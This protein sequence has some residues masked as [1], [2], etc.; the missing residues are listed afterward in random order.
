MVIAGLC[1]LINS[2]AVFLAPAFSRL[3]FPWILLP[4][5]PAELGLALWLLL[6]GVNVGQWKEQPA[7]ATE[8]RS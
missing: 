8:S 1:Y 3:L 2:F 6:K 7:A 4:G 5:L